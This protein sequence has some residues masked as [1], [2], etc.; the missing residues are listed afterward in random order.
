MCFYQCQCPTVCEKFWN[1]KQSHTDA[2]SVKIWC[3]FVVKLM[4]FAHFCICTYQF[5]LFALYRHDTMFSF[6]LNANFT[7]FVV[8]IYCNIVIVVFPHRNT[9]NFFSF[10]LFSWYF[11]L[12]MWSSQMPTSVTMY[13]SLKWT[14]LQLLNAF[15]FVIM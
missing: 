13:F 7:Q 1:M 15:P 11:V 8:D 6:L 10:C 14:A 5:L 4:L 9:I 2:C 3:I 12:Y